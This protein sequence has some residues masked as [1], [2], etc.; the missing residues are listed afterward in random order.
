MESYLMITAIND[1]IFCPRSL[2]FSGIYRHSTDAKMFQQTPQIVGQA[3][4]KSID[5]HMYSTKKSIVT[6]MTVFSQRYNLL[7]VIDILDLEKGV[8]TERKYSVTAVYDGFRY[9]LYAQYFA[10]VEMGF[11]VKQ[12]KLHSVKDNKTY[13][14]D[15]PSADDI[16]DFENVLTQIRSFS[17]FEPCPVTNPNK[18]SHCIYRPLCDAAADMEDDLKT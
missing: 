10:L 11:Q 13:P 15:L 6:G 2:F 9:Q 12:L 14:V 8:L 1:F 18:C 5:Q 7:G 3:N 4:H 17:I 16:A